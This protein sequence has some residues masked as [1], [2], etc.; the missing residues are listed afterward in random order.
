MTGRIGLALVA[1]ALLV[2]LFILFGLARPM[3]AQ[4]LFPTPE[5]RLGGRM[6]LPTAESLPGGPLPQDTP[7]PS[8]HALAGA[9]LLT[10]AEPDQAPAQAVLGDDGMV[11]FIDA[12][13]N[14]GAGIWVPNGEQGGVLAIVVRGGRRFKSATRN[15][16]PAGSDRGRD[17]GRCGNAELR[18]H[19]GDGRRIGSRLGAGRSVHRHRPTCGRAAH[20][21]DA[22]LTRV[23]VAT[24]ISTSRCLFGPVFTSLASYRCRC[25]VP[26]LIARSWLP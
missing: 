14:R 11:T 16:D 17:A 18:L 24:S 10:F 23:F 4:D 6:P 9:W 19:G 21:P 2:G 25:R 26:E 15:D 3:S 12:D 13:G 5:G 8:G 22:G 20:R 1:G 7:A